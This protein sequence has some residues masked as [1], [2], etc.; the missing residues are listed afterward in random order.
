VRLVRLLG[1]DGD[2]AAAG[3]WPARPLALRAAWRRPL[4][5]R[6]SLRALERSGSGQS[7][8][9]AT[10]SAMQRQ[11]DTNADKDVA[12]LVCGSRGWTDEDAVRTQLERA[13]ARFGV[14]RLVVIA[15]GARGADRQ[16]EASARALDVAVEVYPARWDRQGRSAGYRRNTQTLDR[17]ADFPHRCVIAFS[18]GTRGT[19]HTIEQARRRGIPVRVIGKEAR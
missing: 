3:S 6:A 11:P 18:N 5:G 14:E 19:Q 13:A 15:G 9:A 12:V 7:R 2:R 17:L 10:A 1:T 8:S 4:S 16:A